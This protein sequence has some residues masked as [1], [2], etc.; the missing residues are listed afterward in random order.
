MEFCVNSSESSEVKFKLNCSTNKT[1]SFSLPRP[2]R[3]IHCSNQPIKKY[4]KDDKMAEDY[5]INK[6]I[7]GYASEV[8]DLACAGYNWQGER[9]NQLILPDGGFK[10]GD[11]ELVV[12]NNV[13]AKP[14]SLLPPFI[15]IFSSE[16]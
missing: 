14:K 15:D 13:T 9:C 7:K 3:Y 5:V 11:S 1:F 12:Y 2:S 8:L 10:D 16:N 4:C 6:M